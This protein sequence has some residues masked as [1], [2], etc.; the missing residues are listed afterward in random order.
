MKGTI[1][2]KTHKFDTVSFLSGLVISAIGLIYLL[3]NNPGDIWNALTSVGSWFWPVVLVAVALA[4][5][6]PLMIPN[7]SEDESAEEPA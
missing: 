1:N 4:V 6:I 3:T 7:K 2:M 5:L